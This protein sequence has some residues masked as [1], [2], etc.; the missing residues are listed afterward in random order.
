MSKIEIDYESRRKA[1]HLPHRVHFVTHAITELKKKIL[2]VEPCLDDYADKLQVMYPPKGSEYDISSN[3]FKIWKPE[4][5]ISYK[6]QEEF[7]KWLMVYVP[8]EK[9]KINNGYLNIKFPRELFAD[10]IASIIK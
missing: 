2:F 10:V 5:S 1:W 4:M 9:V 8:H 7:L 3:V 6:T